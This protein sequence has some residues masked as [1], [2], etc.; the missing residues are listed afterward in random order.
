MGEG[1]F[2]DGS[3]SLERTKVLEDENRALH[4]E[5]V[6]LR[7]QLD[8][9]QIDPDSAAARLRRIREEHDELLKEVKEL[10]EAMGVVAPGRGG[11]TVIS[12]LRAQL[13]AERE[14]NRDSGGGRAARIAALTVERDEYS[15]RIVA[16]AAERD[17]YS[18]RIVA[19]AAERDE[20]DERIVA[21]TAE[22]DAARTEL[23]HQG[24]LVRTLQQ[25]EGEL[26]SIR[27]TEEAR[28]A[29]ED[30]ITDNRD[31]FVERLQEERDELLAE[32]RK[33]RDAAARQRSGASRPAS[34]PSALLTRLGKLFGR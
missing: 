13:A 27:A 1:A 9:A 20:R 22:R 32:V 6:A 19:L 11:P 25:R 14:E 26:E 16:L 17:E 15:A 2:R 31:A 10:R 29:L 5:I 4:E 7:A 33:Q 28:Q 30:A 8:G 34:S 18:A 23:S 3:A 24:S 21:L 12:R